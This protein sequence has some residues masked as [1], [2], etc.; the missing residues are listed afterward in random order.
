MRPLIALIVLAAVLAGCGSS[1][2]KQVRATI[3]AELRAQAKHD[4]NGVCDLRTAAGQRDF[5]RTSLRPN[6][7]SCAEAWTPAPSGNE[8]IVTLEFKAPTRRLTDV[9]VEDAVATARYDDGSLQRLRKI[10]GR[11]LIDASN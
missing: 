1:D 11:W 3:A 8:P 7:G 6:A 2:E 10:D 5:L 4:W 9:D